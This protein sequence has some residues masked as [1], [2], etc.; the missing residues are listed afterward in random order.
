MNYELYLKEKIIRKQFELLPLKYSVTI[1]HKICFRAELFIFEPQCHFSSRGKQVDQPKF[2]FLTRL[3]I[4]F[5][6][7][8]PP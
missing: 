5:F 4:F 6:F 2:S 8:F 7:A 3:S 1:L